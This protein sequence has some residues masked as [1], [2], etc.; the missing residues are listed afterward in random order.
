MGDG[1]KPITCVLQ[2]AYNSFGNAA[3]LK[4]YSML[5]PLITTTGTP[6]PSIGIS[7]DFNETT[8]LSTPQPTASNQPLW[9]N[10]NWG[11]FSWSNAPTTTN[12]WGASQGIGHYVSPMVLLTTYP[13][14]GNPTFVDTTQLNGWNILAESGAFV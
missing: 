12:N 1:T 7:T 6:V 2:Q 5:Q 11:Q 8:S 13:D 14:I 9:G 4:R 3:Q 10:V